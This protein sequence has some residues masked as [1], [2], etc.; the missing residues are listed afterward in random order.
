[1]SDSQAQ[2]ERVLRES[3]VPADDGPAEE[4]M[5]SD[6]H[7]DRTGEA[8]RTGFS[9]MRTD[10]AGDDGRKVAE[11]EALSDAIVRRRF[12]VAF[13]IEARVWRSVRRQRYSEETGEYLVYEDGTPQWEKDEYG[14]VIEDWGLLSDTARDDLLM[15]IAT[16]MFEWEL[17][18]ASM[19]AE[20]MY[21]KGAWEE[22]FSR[23]YTSLPGHVVSGKPTI[24]DRTHHSQKNAAQERYFAL[25]KSSLSR[26]ADGAVKAMY[27]FQRTLENTRPR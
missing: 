15:S 2:I 26:K 12:A 9:R 6:P 17:A 20:A 27:G 1:M 16:H 18:K 24:E 10:W 5:V 13:A 14:D 22:I 8:S 19:W 25:F 7:P 11:L 4:T 23:G 21:A 3:D